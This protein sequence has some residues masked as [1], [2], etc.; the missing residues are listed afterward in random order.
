MRRAWLAL[1]GVPAAAMAVAIVAAVAG[2]GAQACTSP[3]PSPVGGVPAQLVPIF[4][5][6]AATYDLGPE[7][8]AILA[9]INY[10]ESDF[11]SDEPGV[12]SGANNAGA[13]GP[14]QIGIGGA[15]TD[16]WDTVVREIPRK[17][18]GGARPPSVYNEV[19]AV[20]AAAALLKLWGAPGDW[21]AALVAWNDYPPEIA[22]V[23]Q[24]AAQ[25]IQNGEGHGRA[26]EGT[27]T[28]GAGA[29]TE[30]SGGCMPISGVTTP[31]AVAQIL[32][33]GAATIPT[34]APIQVQEAIA[35]GNRIIDTFYSQERRA[36]MLTQVQ[37]SYDCSGATDFVLYNAG[38]SSPQVDVGNGIAGASGQLEN[39]GVRGRGRWISV[40]GSAGHAFIE[41]AGIVLDT[42]HYAAVEPASVRDSYPADDPANAGPASGPRWQ[43]ASI[44][45]SQLGDGNSW[46][47]GHPSGL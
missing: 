1:L 21:Q 41:V 15:A 14:M 25:Y 43:P 28:A 3:L 29:T 23:T 22:E 10:A 42:A 12:H 47:V 4:R 45:P 34:G 32:P 9:A 39:Y 40:Y 18:F 13:A 38:L 33:D 24:L 26:A 44:I 17:L 35:A 2:S 37:D 5:G 8:A 27:S 16:N 6:A 11:D 31:G 19:D 36:N 46:S 7:G 30:P 20:Y